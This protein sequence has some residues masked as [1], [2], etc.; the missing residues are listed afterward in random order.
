[1]KLYDYSSSVEGDIVGPE[2]A[3]QRDISS[4]RTPLRRA[5]LHPGRVLEVGSTAMLPDPKSLQ[6]FGFKF[7]S[8]PGWRLVLVRTIKSEFEDFALQIQKI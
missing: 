6:Y 7:R 2:S 8:F 1:M 3:V 4:A 5:S